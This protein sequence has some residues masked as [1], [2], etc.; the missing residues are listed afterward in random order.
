MKMWL[1][2]IKASQNH[3]RLHKMSWHRSVEINQR[4]PKWWSDQHC[5]ALNMLLTKMSSTD[6]SLS[7][8]FN[9][10]PVEKYMMLQVKMVLFVSCCLIHGKVLWHM[11]LHIKNTIVCAHVL[12]CV[13]W[14][15]ISH[16]GEFLLLS[17]THSLTSVKWLPL[18]MPLTT[19]LQF[20]GAQSR[21]WE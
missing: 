4:G 19:A 3:K 21:D 9:L 17:S 7:A 1:I 8:V 16:C 2:H 15:I 12:L 6:Q 20:S 13:R 11:F 18:I 10:L 14:W 5:H